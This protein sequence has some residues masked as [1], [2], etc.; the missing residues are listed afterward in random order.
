MVLAG[1][2]GD[3]DAHPPHSIHGHVFAV[4]SVLVS[5]HS[6]S[7]GVSRRLESTHNLAYLLETKHATLKAKQLRSMVES[8]S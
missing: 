3:R 7:G 6:V 1:L 4:V 2:H 5:V 8:D